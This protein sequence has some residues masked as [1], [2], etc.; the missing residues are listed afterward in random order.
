MTLRAFIRSLVLIVPVVVLSTAGASAQSSRST[1]PKRMDLT[2]VR[3]N[4]QG[5][6]VVLVLGNTHAP[7]NNVDAKAAAE[8]VPEA[9]RKALAD[10]KDFLPYKRYQLID[11][12]WMLCCASFSDGPGVSGRMRGPDNREYTYSIEPNGTS[13]GKLNLR[14]SLREVTGTTPALDPKGMTDSAKLLYQQQLHEAVKEAADATLEMKR[15]QQRYPVGMMTE[16][17]YEK[18]KQRVQFAEQRVAE[19]APNAN[20]GTTRAATRAMIDST[21]AIT[22]GETVVIGTSRVAGDQAL[23]ALLTAAT[24]PAGTR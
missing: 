23:I 9:A 11:A 5:F 18:A 12:A 2:T 21:F 22:P 6:S 7:A 14:F 4:I 15:A 17:E 10:M 3:S 8:G 16:T 13:D 24:R 19:L 1:T 20:G